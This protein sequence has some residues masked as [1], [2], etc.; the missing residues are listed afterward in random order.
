M[1]PVGECKLLPVLRDGCDWAGVIS[2][3][4]VTVDFLR[5][6]GCVVISMVSECVREV[7]RAIFPLS[8]AVY[9]RN[10]LL[11]CSGLSARRGIQHSIDFPHALCH[12]ERACVF[13]L[14]GV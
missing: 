1:D 11:S 6:P 14:A 13:Y 8:V 12:V 3:H 5:A 7:V 9:D 2:W 10:L 4:G